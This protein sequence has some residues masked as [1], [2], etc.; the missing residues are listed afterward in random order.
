MRV[1]SLIFA[2]RSER[3]PSKVVTL[4]GNMLTSWGREFQAEGTCA[5]ALRQEYVKHVGGITR[6]LVWLKLQSKGSDTERGS[7]GFQ[8]LWQRWCI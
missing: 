3:D 5:K 1:V 4:S 6:G 7:R 8:R 2:G